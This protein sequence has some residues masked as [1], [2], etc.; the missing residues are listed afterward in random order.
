M[1]ASPKK[2]VQWCS[3]DGCE[4]RVKARGVC[5]KHWQELR[6]AEGFICSIDGCSAALSSGGLCN[7]H[8]QERYKRDRPKAYRKGLEPEARF[9][10]KVNPTGFCW[11]WTGALDDAGYGVFNTGTKVDRAH[12]LSYEYLVGAIPGGKHIDHL[13]RNRKCCNPDHLEPVDPIENWRRGMSPAAVVARTDRCVRGHSMADAYVRPGTKARM[14]RQCA[15]D[16][17][18]RRS[19]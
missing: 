9:W 10:M 16:R 11:E 15:V 7:R 8:W 17:Q 6:A 1:T 14:C 13:C 12:R 5:T 4:R 19:R 2:V 18:E 3:Q